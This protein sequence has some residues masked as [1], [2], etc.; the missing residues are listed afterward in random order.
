MKFNRV[1]SKIITLANGTR[2][3]IKYWPEG[4]SICVAAFDE[5]DKQITVATYS[6]KVDIADDFHPTFEQS[7]I[8]GLVT[9][10][11]GDLI[12]HPELHIRYK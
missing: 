12:N 4:T 5:N 3:I 2:A 1:P 6:A 7:L 11:E 8:D 9:I 10:V